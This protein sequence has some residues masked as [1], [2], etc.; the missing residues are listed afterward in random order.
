MP[1]LVTT[2]SPSAYPQVTPAPA[3]RIVC[4]ELVDTEAESKMD[5]KPS[6]DALP[7]RTKSNTRTSVNN[8][9][10]TSSC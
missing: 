1:N 6:S 3:R 2:S 10:T 7:H 9:G 5:W 4:P 8:A